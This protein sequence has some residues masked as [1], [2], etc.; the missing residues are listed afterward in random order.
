MAGSNTFT[1]SYYGGRYSEN[2]P[3]HLGDV[4]CS[5]A[6][7]R[8]IDCPYHTNTSGIDAIMRCNSGK[9]WTGIM[10]HWDGAFFYSL[11]MFTMNI[12]DE[13]MYI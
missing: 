3:I 10:C 12:S 7:F 6:E 9:Y 2:I 1:A 4:T 5:G 11:N 8:L 13:L